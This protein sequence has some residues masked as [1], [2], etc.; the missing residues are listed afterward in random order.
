M[1][2]KEMTPRERVLRALNFQETDRCPRDLGGTNNS[3]IHIDA[4]RALLSHMHMEDPG[5]TWMNYGQQLVRPGEAVLDRLGIDTRGVYPSLFAPVGGEPPALMR[6]K[7][8][9]EWKYN[10]SG[11]YYD[12]VNFPLADAAD[13]DAVRTYPFPEARELLKLDGVADYAERLH[14]QNR[15]A[16]VGYFGSSIF[17]QAQ[18]LRGYAQLF[19]D[20]L[21][22]EE[23]FVLLMQRILQVR[24]GLA[25][26]F[27]DTCGRWLDVVVIAD[28]IAS[29]NGPLF[30]PELYRRLV[31]PFTKALIDGIRLRTDARILYHSC[32]AVAGFL[33]DFAAIGIDAVNPVQVSAEG[34]GDIAALKAGYH[35]RLTFWGGIDT[36]NLLPAGT[37]EQVRERTA[38]TCRTMGAGGGYVLCASHN[39]HGDIPPENITAMYEAGI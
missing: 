20:M 31:G 30:S 8:G 6:D 14:Q 23:L 35:G 21:L 33:D 5:M 4:Y 18:L 24:L 29:Q 1:N 22:D 36:Q 9:I 17:M 10:P 2:E 7:W 3:S 12:A 25:E 13:M 19:E 27:L 26:L 38:F 34:M 11:H 16:A 32:G 37:P 15:Y 39:L 28:D